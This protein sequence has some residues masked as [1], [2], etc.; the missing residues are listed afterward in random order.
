MGKSTTIR[1][2]AYSAVVCA[3]AD[4]TGTVFTEL[5][6]IPDRVLNLRH[7]L[8]DFGIGKTP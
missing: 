3:V 8:A 7:L 2:N 6:L 4:A 1:M 5:P